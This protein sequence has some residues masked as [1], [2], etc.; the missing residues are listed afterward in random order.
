MS[1]EVFSNVCTCCPSPL[2]TLV[3]LVS[4]L[5]QCSCRPGLVLVPSKEGVFCHLYQ[6]IHHSK[7]K[8]FIYF[9]K[10]ADWYLR[11]LSTSDLIWHC[12]Y[13]L[14][15]KIQW[16]KY[17][18]KSNVICWSI[19]I[20]LC[21]NL[22]FPTPSMHSFVWSYK[23]FEYLRNVLLPIV[24]W[25]ALMLIMLPQYVPYKWNWCPKVFSAL[26][27]HYLDKK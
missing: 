16:S 27:S 5:S 11:Q 8:A 19:F 6:R 10:T 21:R 14:S 4:N 13:I 20:A 7:S 3:L 2:H 15:A 12:I 23:P 1:V 25:M 24:F 22:F 9:F 26:T 18:K 17:L